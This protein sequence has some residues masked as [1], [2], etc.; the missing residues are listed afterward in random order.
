MEKAFVT[1]W[2]IIGAGHIARK[3]A[4]A[5]SAAPGARLHAI[6]SQDIQ[7]AEAYAEECNVPHA[8]GSHE[9]ILDIPEIDIVYI[10]TTHNFHHRDSKL[11]LEAGLP[12][13]CEKPF[14]LR[15]DELED[16]VDIARRKKLFL[17]E[18]MWTR[19]LPT[20]DKVLE[21]I[22]EDKLG[23]IQVVRADFGMHR[24][25]DPEHRLFNKALGGGSLMDIGVYPLFLALLL[26]GMPEE[27]NAVGHFGLTG[28]DESCVMNLKHPNGVVSGLQ[29]TFLSNTPCEAEIFGEK[30]S[31]KINS[32]WYAPSSV[33]FHPRKGQEQEFK[34]EYLGNG[35][36]LEAIEAMECLRKGMTE[37]K[38]LPLS[39]SLDLMRLVEKVKN[40]I[41]LEYHPEELI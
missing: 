9:E 28:V 22:R 31:I 34:F 3:F 2:G 29:T 20:I 7:R 30:G 16:L 38:K 24:E 19:F 5:L 40:E 10:A 23:K 11:C 21:L 26:N 36:H 13:L 33:T 41:N 14:T 25:F 27:M 35:Y 4:K 6:A 1:H 39:F 17:M 32:K 37:S 18:A 8:V 12:V 15:L